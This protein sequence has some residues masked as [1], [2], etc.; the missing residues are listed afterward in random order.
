MN[1]EKKR[2]FIINFIY[3]MIVALIAFVALKYGIGWFLPFILAL[4]IT[5]AMR[6]LILLLTKKAKIPYRIASIVVLALFFAIVGVLISL[7]FMRFLLGIK[8]LFSMIP[9]FYSDS[10]EPAFLILFGNIENFVSDFSPDLVFAL[11]DIIPNLIQTLGSMVTSLSKNSIDIITSIVAVIP[12]AFIGLIFTIISSFF[13]T[14]DYDRIMEFIMRQFSP[15]AKSIIY[16]VKHYFVD[17]VFKI[18]R[19]YALLMIL[20]FIELSIGLSI[21]RVNNAIA[22]AG[23]IALIDILPVLGT[24]GILVPWAV[25][26][27]ILGNYLFAIGI[28]VMYLIITVVRNVLEPKIVGNQIGLHP[29]AT[30]ISMYIGNKVMGIL[31]IFLFPMIVITLKKLNSTNKIHL[32][33]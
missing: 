7:L 1:L 27:A 16:D 28:V 31:G 29:I 15:R 6:P 9:E 20:T 14:L 33:K 26:E 25:I 23:L 18:L 32:F 13:L 3:F 30:L 8:D 2:A 4:G 19:V 17:S 12:S 24:G 11:E 21:L 5:L 22:V 10:V